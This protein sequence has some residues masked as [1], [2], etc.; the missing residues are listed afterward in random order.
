M[1][2][3]KY[4]NLLIAFEESLMEKIHQKLKRQ[5]FVT[6]SDIQMNSN[7]TGPALKFQSSL[8]LWYD[9][10]S[11]KVLWYDSQYEGIVV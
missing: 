1:E 6:K 11:M 3:G 4:Y 8:V 7:T 10:V 2:D 5:E 9:T